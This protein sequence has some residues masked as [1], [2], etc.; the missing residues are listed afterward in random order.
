MNPWQVAQQIQFALR[1]RRWQGDGAAE[2]VFHYA[3]V[4]VTGGLTTEQFAR[5]TPPT[6][7]IVP[8]AL[9][10][11]TDLHGL[12][13]GS[14]AVRVTAQNVDP[15]GESVLI[16]GNR[17]G[18][19]GSSGGR[20]LLEIEAEVLATIEHLNRVIGFKMTG[21][22]DG[23]PE[24]AY[25]GELAYIASRVGTFTTECTR[26]PYYHPPQ[27]LVATA[28]GSGTVVL[29]W[30]NPPERF[31]FH[32]TLTP[33]WEAARGSLIL[34]RASGSTPPAS[35]TA[36]DGVTLAGAFS[37]GVTDSPGAGT[38]SYA[39]FAAYDETGSGTAERYSDQE[40]GTTRTVVAT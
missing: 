30:A 9:R 7:Y 28:G 5:M 16:G 24:V 1:T 23:A 35:A 2:L 20:G 19:Q 12:S 39:L 36:G 11:D 29:A 21:G 38:W 8:G 18:G 14:F 33:A 25:D 17:T 40:T 32:D 37:T 34:R 15:V 31:D 13:D 26:A 27:R 6:A 10:A 3:S 22:F 4:R